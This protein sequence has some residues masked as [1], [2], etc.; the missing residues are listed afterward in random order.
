MNHPNDEA[1]DKLL[2]DAF[3]GPVT[4]GGFSDRVMQ[5]LPRRRRARSWILVAGICSG[6][7]AV[8]LALGPAPVLRAGWRDWLH[9]DMSSAAIILLLVVVAMSLLGL[10][11]GLDEIEDRQGQGLGAPR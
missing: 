9:H 1:L 10:V 5:V 6:V 8:W 4:D 3:D 11:W 2:R 7:I